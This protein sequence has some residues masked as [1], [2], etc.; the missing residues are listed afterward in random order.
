MDNRGRNS[1]AGARLSRRVVLGVAA[2]SWV[3]APAFAVFEVTGRPKLRL[4]T[5]FG[6]PIYVPDGSGYFNRLMAGAAERIGYGVEIDAPPA[7][8]ALA[9]ANAGII[10][11]DGPRIPDLGELGNYPNLMRVPEALMIA[12]FVGFTH[13]EALPRAHW[14][15]LAQLD[16]GI[17]RGWKVLEQNITRSRSLFRTKTATLL[18]G[19]LRDRRIDVALIDR[20]SGI[21]AARAAGVADIRVTAEPFVQRPMYLHLHKRHAA[22]VEPLT[23]ALREMRTD[24]TTAQIELETLGPYLDRA[25]EAAVRP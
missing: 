16:V 12:D 22:L 15:T 5:A 7:E 9:I 14:E 17:V 10:D 1:D 19:L 20:M 25:V 21:A 4:S 6:P 24:G 13:G 23:A 11:G 8:R 3:H 2:L 18:F